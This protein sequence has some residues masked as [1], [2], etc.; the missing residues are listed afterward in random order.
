VAPFAW[1][2]VTYTGCAATVSM[3]MTPSVFGIGNVGTD[4]DE[5]ALAT[6]LI[7]DDTMIVLVSN[8][9]TSVTGGI[10]SYVGLLADLLRRHR[11]N[12]RLIAYNP[13]FA[14][15]EEHQAR[16]PL[17]RLLHALFFFSAIG[18]IVALR[19]K[20][21]RVIVHSHS[22]SFCLLVA[23][24]SRLFGCRGIHTFHS[25]PPQEGSWILRNLAPSLDGI[26]H[27]SKASSRRYSEVHR[28]RNSRT[29]VIPGTVLPSRLE[30]SA[31]DGKGLGNRVIYLGRIVADKGIDLLI[32][33]M[34]GLVSQFPGIHLDVVGPPGGAE[35]IER[36]RTMVSCLGLESTVTFRGEVDARSKEALLREA[37]IVVLPSRW[38]EPA[39]IV[40][41]EAMSHGKPVVAANVGGLPEFVEDGKTGVLF[42]PGNAEDLRSK[43]GMLLR[44]ASLRERLGIGG[45]EAYESQL[46]PGIFVRRHLSVYSS[47]L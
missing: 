3:S 26:V 37:G 27:V 23:W 21:S 7:R 20:Y 29:I 6:S 41:F 36:L 47:V 46:S 38:P 28:V 11:L 14:R 39:P 44:D 33:A 34:A 40:A 25:P 8:I 10:T 2:D 13:A 18:T 31:D 1:V 43:L 15:S 42:E 24:W 9:P 22:A 4:D 16:S 12:V 35:Y 32:D 30:T 5:A 17:A 45:R 19:V